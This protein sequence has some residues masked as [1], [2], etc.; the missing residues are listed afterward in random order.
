LHYKYEDKNVVAGT[1]YYYRLQQID[2]DG[3]SEITNIVS[4]ALT[5]KGNIK[6]MQL[7]P[8]PAE[9]ASSVVVNTSLE[10]DATISIIDI[11]GTLAYQKTTR[12][13]NGINNFDLDLSGYAKGTYIVTINTASETFSRQLVVK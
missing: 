11:R 13:Y 12:L 4:A 3:A 5:E 8:N 10:N 6:W 1:R 2:F 7:L 9:Q